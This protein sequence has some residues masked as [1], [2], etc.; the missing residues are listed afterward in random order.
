VESV[1]QLESTFITDSKTLP[2]KPLREF[3]NEEIMVVPRGELIKLNFTCTE[4]SRVNALRR[5]LG[6]API[7][8]TT[9]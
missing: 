8:D 5:Y 7:F 1:R 9:G 3:S 4:R 6:L 2:Y